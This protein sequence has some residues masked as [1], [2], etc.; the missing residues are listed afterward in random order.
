MN[1][2][3]TPGRPPVMK[4]DYSQLKYLEGAIEVRKNKITADEKRRMERSK[5]RSAVTPSELRK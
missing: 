5:L 4:F 1:T 3:P 2:Y